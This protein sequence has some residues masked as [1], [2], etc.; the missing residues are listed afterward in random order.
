MALAAG[1]D[2]LVGKTVSVSLHLRSANALW[3]V[4]PGIPSGQ[5]GNLKVKDF[6]GNQF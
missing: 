3:W 2:R 4:T 1:P 6:L 5:T